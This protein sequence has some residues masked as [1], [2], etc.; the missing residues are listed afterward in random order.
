MRV[1]EKGFSRILQQIHNG[2]RKFA[3]VYDITYIGEYE[4]GVD[5]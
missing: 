3:A 5:K 2:Q 1:G 4:N